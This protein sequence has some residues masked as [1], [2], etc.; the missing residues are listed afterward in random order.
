M[1]NKKPI[2]LHHPLGGV[3]KRSDHQS[4]PPYTTPYALNV[5]PAT[6]SDQRYR[7]GTR[8]GLAK[9][10]AA[11]VSS[12][13][14]RLIATV[15]YIA[16]NTLKSKVVTS[17]AGVLKY[18]QTDGTLSSSVS[19]SGLSTPAVVISN[20][21]LVH[22]VDILQKLYIADWD[23]AYSTADRA[24]KVFDPSA[25]TLAKITASAGT[26]PLGNPCVARYRGRLCLGGA[27]DAP[28][29]WY[30]SEVAD[31]TNWDYSVDEETAAFSS[32]SS[33]AFSLGDPITALIATSDECMII[34]CTTSLWILRN[35]P[36]SGGSM[37]NLSPDIGIVS[38]GAW[39]TTPEGA[40]VFLSHDGL[41]QTYGG[42]ADHRPESLSRERMPVA[43]LNLGNSNKIINLAYDIFARGVHIRV[44]D[45]TSTG[46]STGMIAIVDGVVTLTG[47]TWPSWAADG[48]LNFNGTPLEVATRDSSTQLTLVDTTI[49]LALSSIPFSLSSPPEHYFFDWENKSFWP[50]QYPFN[51]DCTA[52]HAWRNYSAGAT[53]TTGLAAAQV[54]NPAPTA[55]QSTGGRSTILF[56]CRDGYIRR[57]NL[58]QTTD[59]GAPIASY[60]W[61]GPVGFGR[62]YYESAIDEICATMAAS[63]GDVTWS[64]Y[65]GSS[66]EEAFAGTPLYTYTGTFTAPRWNYAF[67]PRVGG[68]DLYIKVSGTSNAVW[69][70]ERI[71]LLIAALGGVRR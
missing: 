51:A 32:S 36:R 59:D 33:P 68:S 10:F 3:F 17:A 64:I 23:P 60:L 18:E 2:E 53:Y 39:C 63:S 31:P 9:A 55:A 40:V 12:G 4:Q 30:A 43:L 16:S 49:D 56:G 21:Q 22:A 15:Q 41:Y 1:P 27:S 8:P 20:T 71:S 65:A 34:G 52:I 11:Q 24:P 38:H 45:P 44:S 62:G 61:Y 5:R 70:V 14:V 46:Y 19:C 28:H 69:A 37:N 58:D 13:E 26:V 35:D 66:P 6:T 50:E 25:N 57:L 42:C 48:Y 54:L 7:V 67:C 29:Q 47:G